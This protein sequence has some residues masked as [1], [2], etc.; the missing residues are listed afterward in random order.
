MNEDFRDILTAFVEE[1]VRF[2]VV[3]AYAMAVHGVPRATGDLDLWIDLDEENARRAWR[4]LDAFGAPAEA[5]GVTLADLSKP[6]IVIQIGLPPRRIDVMTGITGVTFDEAWDDRTVHAM[7]GVEV[8]FLGRRSLIQN[9]RA[10]DRPKDR[11]DLPLLEA[12]DEASEN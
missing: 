9:K 4:A 12:E 7:A 8:P 5:L 1:R 3:G 2:L 11:V 10:T 6:G